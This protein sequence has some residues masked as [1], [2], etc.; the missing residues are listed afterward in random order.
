MV[1]V[2][3]GY[4]SRNVEDRRG[5]RRSSGGGFGFPTRRSSGGGGLGGGLGGG[6]L[7]G[8]MGGGSL[9]PGGAPAGRRGCG[10]GMG[11]IIVLVLVVL[12]ASQCLGGGDSVPTSTGGT[13]SSG[14]TGATFDASN[15]SAAEN[16]AFDL[17]NFVLDDV[18]DFW[19]GEFAASGQQYPEAGLVIFDNGVSTR[20][21]GNASSNVG[22]FYC[23]ADS[24]AYIDIQ[25]MF[26][27]Q[28]Q[29]GAEGDFAQAYILA[30]EIG[31]HVQNVR[32]INDEVRRRQSGASRAVSNGLQ[33]R[34]ELQADCLAGM[35]ARDAEI[36]GGILEAG[37]L[38]EGVDAAG[39]VG[40]DA[41][42]GSSNSENFTH[43]TS[44]QRVRWFTV[45][46]DTGS[47]D[48]C[49][50]LDLSDGEL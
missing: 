11:M 30:H 27:L 31:H 9:S 33:V 14:G 26:R 6:G 44:A 1:K 28:A 35:W 22:P 45:G 5:S 48:A 32:G 18:Q 16:E 12:L 47:F 40:D 19:A 20:G 8:Q 21:C 7:G 3:K 36:R 25:F 10:G 24:K 39:A 41:I 50:T 2:P 15:Y 38:Q 4:R 13:S 17:A 37:D 49:S 42:T 46:F 29:L 34:M 43:G 23:P